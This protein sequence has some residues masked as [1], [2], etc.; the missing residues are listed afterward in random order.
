[1]WRKLLIIFNDNDNDLLTQWNESDNK[2]LH[3]R[4]D[5]KIITKMSEEI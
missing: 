2:Y 5:E 3:M 4:L 1:M